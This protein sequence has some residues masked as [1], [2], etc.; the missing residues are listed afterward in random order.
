MI[1]RRTRCC[2]A[3]TMVGALVI[4]VGCRASAQEIVAGPADSLAVAHLTGDLAEALE[5]LAQAGVDPTVEQWQTFSAIPPV[6]PDTSSPWQGQAFWRAEMTKERGLGHLGRVDLGQA[7]WRLRGKIKATAGAPGLVTGTLIVDKARFGLY[8]GQVGYAHGYGLLVAAPGRSRT[9]AA[10]VSL[11][12]RRSG[13]VA[14]TSTA[15]TRTLNGGAIKGRI[16]NWTLDLMSG[17][18]SEPKAP[19]IHY[20]QPILAALSY[21]TGRQ[22]CGVLVSRLSGQLGASLA[23]DFQNRAW[24]VAFEGATWRRA[25]RT[26]LD[27]AWQVMLEWRHRQWGR[28]MAMTGAGLGPEGSL[29]GVRAP[30]APGWYGGNWALSAVFRPGPG[31]TLRVLMAQAHHRQTLVGEER[32]RVQNIDVQGNWR[33][34][35]SDQ[36]SARYRLRRQR[37]WVWDDRYPWQAPVLENQTDRTVLT[38]RFDRQRA[39]WSGQVT[40]RTASFSGTSLPGKRS[41]MSVGGRWRW[42]DRWWLRGAWTSAWGDPVDLVSA[43]CPMPGLVLPRHWG[44]WRSEIVGGV[45][46]HWHRWRFYLAASLRRPDSPMAATSTAAWSAFQWRW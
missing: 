45:E 32:H 16:G 46:M 11:A 8:L 18:V 15:D 2:C 24:R 44:H 21:G 25:D 34:S 37:A 19:V 1:R 41:L 43:I 12:P 30:G 10:G 9:L 6:D 35:D 27:G 26:S 28:L 20:D 5:E 17:Q 4:L 22:R 7:W 36:V 13:P 31:R 14:W 29:Q 42:S 23:G 40:V 39:N 33:V 3:M 38:L